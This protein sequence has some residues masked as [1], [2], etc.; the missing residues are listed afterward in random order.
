MGK[1]SAGW[2]FLRL[3]CGF[4]DEPLQISEGA[5]GTFYSCPRYPRCF[6]RMNTELYERILERVTALI[7]DDPEMN[8]TGYEWEYRTPQRYFRFKIKRQTPSHCFVYVWN[9]KKG[10]RKERNKE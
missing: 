4:C 6:N 7:T 2:E 10:Q 1:V 9:M 5:W 3:Y 8:Y